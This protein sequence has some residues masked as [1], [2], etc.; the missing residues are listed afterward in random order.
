M[1]VRLRSLPGEL[2][3]S[4]LESTQTSADEHRVA[5]RQRYVHI[6]SLMYR[7]FLYLTIQHSDKLPPELADRVHSLAYEA[8]GSCFLTNDGIGIHHRYEG[9]W[10]ACRLSCVQILKLRA[11]ERAGFLESTRF[12]D[13]GYTEAQWK[14][15]L[16]VHKAMID[17]WAQESADVAALRDAVDGMAFANTR[18]HMF[19]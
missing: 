18:S 4:H 2:N 13:A 14:R 15:S 1:N 3:F 6:R 19:I 10:F 9:T 16:V 5:L 12:R 11:A 7:P 17:Y 8:I